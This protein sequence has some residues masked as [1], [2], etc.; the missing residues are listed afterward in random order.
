MFGPGQ[1][2]IERAFD[3]A[4]RSAEHLPMLELA[5][6]SY[7]NHATAAAELGALLG[8]PA[9]IASELDG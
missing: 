8:R 3:V 2:L 4:F 6:E 7:A 9:R 1:Q 5:R